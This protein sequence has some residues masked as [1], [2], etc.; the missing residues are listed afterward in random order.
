[1]NES[2]T[3]GE[4]PHCAYHSVASS[5]C[6]AC[7]DAPLTRGG[8]TM[9]DIDRKTQLWTAL[10]TATWRAAEALDTGTPGARQ[11]ALGYRN[12]LMD[13]WVILTDDDIVSVSEKLQDHLVAVHEYLAE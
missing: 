11:A 1:M 4:L 10:A 2:P 6:K 3:L 12:G 8:L 13:A 9:L 7:A 5:H